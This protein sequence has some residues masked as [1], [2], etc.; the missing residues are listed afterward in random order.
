MSVATICLM[1]LN[2]PLDLLGRPPSEVD[3]AALSDAVTDLKEKIEAAETDLQARRSSLEK[4]REDYSALLGYR[5]F[6]AHF[7]RAEAT[8]KKA[9][10]VPSR[11]GGKR[12][13]LIALLSDG[14]ALSVANI[15]G[16]LRDQ[17]LMTDR[18]AEYHSLQV[19]LSRMFRNGEL[20]RP[21]QGM[22]QLPVEGV[23]A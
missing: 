10:L 5:N 15:A 2:D 19:I 14:R 11:R 6:V 9:A 16:A 1:V 20:E 8:P 12:L 13:A 18:N 4:T 3:L 23:E 22:Y 7:A 21:S 17:G